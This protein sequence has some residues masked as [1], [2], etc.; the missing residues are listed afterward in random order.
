MRLLA[1][2]VYQRGGA[3]VSG[4]AHG[5]SGCITRETAFEEVQIFER[6]SCTAFFP[7]AGTCAFR[8]APPTVV[9]DRALWPASPGFRSGCGCA[10]GQ[11]PPAQERG[12][13]GSDQPVL[14]GRRS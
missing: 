14:A 2:S 13:D 11:E 9:A 10:A 4:I 12:L 3:A 8:R 1:G 7:I 5:L 6:F